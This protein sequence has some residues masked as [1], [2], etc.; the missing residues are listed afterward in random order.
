MILYSRPGCHLCEEAAAMLE[1]LS[2]E[3]GL[4][5]QEANIEDDEALLARYHLAIPVVAVDGQ[6]VLSAPI[7]EETLQRALIRPLAT[8]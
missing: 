1:R 2:R 4:V 3:T 8:G 7:E 6:D 5:W